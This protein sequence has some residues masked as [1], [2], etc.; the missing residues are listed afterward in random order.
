MLPGRAIVSRTCSF[1]RQV[2]FGVSLLAC[3]VAT[4]QTPRPADG[5]PMQLRPDH[6]TLSVANLDKEVAWYQRVFGFR[7]NVRHKRGPDFE[8]A[9]LSLGVYHVDVAWQKGSVRPKETGYFRQGWMHV[10]FATPAIDAAYERLKKLGTDVYA[11]HNDQGHIW[12]IFLHDPE[13]NEIE[14]VAGSGETLGALNAPPPVPDTVLP[15]GR[16]RALVIQACTACHSAETVAA[17]RRTQA[18]WNRTIARMVVRG[19]VVTRNEQIQILAYLEKNFGLPSPS[20]GP[21]RHP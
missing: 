19:A 5:N 7:E 17:S 3:C 6:V 16:D 18:D 20:S 1:R 2:A 10:V 4:G 13:G 14:I 15:A 8:V 11:D 21:P 12:R 9:H